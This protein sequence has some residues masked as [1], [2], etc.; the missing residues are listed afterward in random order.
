MAV[1]RVAMRVS[2][3][4]HAV[5]EADIRRR[6]AAG[7]KNFETVYKPLVDVWTWYDNSGDQPR[8]MAAGSKS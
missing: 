4:G 6:F 5:P 3:G 1:E 7:W 2:Q 8:L